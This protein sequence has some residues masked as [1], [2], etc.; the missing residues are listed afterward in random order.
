[1]SLIT[2]LQE[3]KELLKKPQFAN[4]SQWQ[5]CFMKMDKPYGKKNPQTME[6]LYSEYSNFFTVHK[7]ILLTKIG[8]ISA[9]QKQAVLNWP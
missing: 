6:S 7:I 9:N 2:S 1:M 4:Q 8:R 3:E 5:A